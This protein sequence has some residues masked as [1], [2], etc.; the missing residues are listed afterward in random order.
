MIDDSTFEKIEAWLSGELTGTEA[1]AFEADIAADAELAAEVQRHRFG[2]LAIDRL[3]EQGIEQDL[4]RWRNTMDDLPQAPPDN[5]APNDKPAPKS[6][7]SRLIIPA[8]LLLLGVG[9]IWYFKQ[10]PPSVNRQ[11]PTVYPPPSNVP[12]PPST[13]PV[14]VVPPPTQAPEAPTTDQQRIAMADQRLTN[15]KKGILQQYGQTMGEEQEINPFFKAG[16]DAFKQKN[17]AKTAKENLLKVP[18]Q[19]PYFA[20]AQ[21]MLASLFYQ[22]KNYSD[23]ARCYEAFAAQNSAPET[24]WRLAQFYLA[25][26]QYRKSDFWKKMDEMLSTAPKHQHQK[27]AKALK[28]ELYRL[29]VKRD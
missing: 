19:D 2:R 18:A 11:P 26:Y 14:A 25:D 28:S 21:E 7:V 13:V 23:A 16:V 15:F 4:A 3:A 8:L 27:E 22:E 9:A 20:P 5:L 12:P 6:S 17:K 10:L 29:G 24:D 1:Q